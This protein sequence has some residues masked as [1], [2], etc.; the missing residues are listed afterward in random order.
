M[1]SVTPRQ[2]DRLADPVVQERTIG[3]TGQKVVL[4]RMSHLPRHRPGR[5][6]VAEH[7]DRSSS[8]PFTIIDRGSGVFDGNFKSVTPDENTIR[9]QVNDSILLNCHHHRIR[10]IFVTSGVLDSYNFGHWPA[11]RLLPRP[12]SHV[13]RND[14]EEGDVSR[15]VRANNGLS[16]AVERDLG[17]IR[18]REQRLFQELALHGMA[19]GSQKPARLDLAFDEIVF[20]AFLQGLYGS[21]SSSKPVSTTNGMRGAAA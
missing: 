12:A 2:R 19:Q 1:I 11:C 7:N 18:F 17:A 20:R 5:A 6:H 8:P 16:N 4:G 15:D 21:D 14:I 13:F 10:D 3:Q 9:R